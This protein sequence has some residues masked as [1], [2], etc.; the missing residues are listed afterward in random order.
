MTKDDTAKPGAA[1][2][3]GG[4]F[5]PQ[6]QLIRGVI[7]LIV[8]ILSMYTNNFSAGTKFTIHLLSFSSFYGCSIWVSFVAGIVMFKNMSRHSFGRLQAKLFPKYFQFSTITI[9]ISIILMYKELIVIEQKQFM[10]LCAIM[11]ITLI[12]LL[13]IEPKTTSIM[14]ERHVI[15]RKLG[16][17][18]E[19]G[20][21]KS[22]DPKIANDS[23]LK[24]ISKRFG[25]FHGI[26]S[27]L[28]LISI[29]LA[30]WHLIFIGSKLKL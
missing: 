23:E 25:M 27:S 9:G 14:Y 11:I 3:A 8:A 6:R 24:A 10:C 5:I 18:H 20:Q 28:N 16:T 1:A 26:S 19:I 30:T 7:I 2:P 12:N 4:F 22:S 29:C 15:E 13:V 21:I 17:G